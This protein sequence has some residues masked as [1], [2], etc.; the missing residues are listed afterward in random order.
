MNKFLISIVCCFCAGSLMT[1]CSVIADTDFDNWKQEFYQYAL[2]KG[3]SKPTLDQYVPQM[4]LLERVVHIDTKKPEYVANFYDY[5][6]S[7]IE[8][9]RINGGRKMAKKYKTWLR[10]V[11]EK[12]GVQ[13][14]YL[15]SFWGMETNY[16]NYMGRVKMLDSLASLSYHPRRRQFFSNELVAYLKI[17]EEEPS[18]APEIGSWD[19]GMGNF[20]FMPTTFRA[21]AVD[22]DNNH[23]R[24]IV[25]NIPDAL[26][27][28]AN[29]LS[30]MG[31]DSTEPWGR[32]IILPKDIDGEDIHH[33]RT[34]TVR[35]WRALGIKPKH[36][37]D[38]PKNEYDIKAY[39]RMPMGKT[40]P[41]FLTYP[42][43]N[44]ILRWNRSELY[45]LSVGILAD[46]LSDRRP[47]LTQPADFVPMKRVWVQQIQE[48]LAEQGLYKGKT[49]GSVG[50]KTRHAIRQYQIQNKLFP[51]GYP[52]KELF[53]KIVGY[54]E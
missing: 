12:Y 26:S 38:F 5:T 46:I 9:L 42:N 32:E 20:Q 25:R 29:Y 24:D 4:K 18:V 39:L 41:V 31:W 30:A 44:I 13:P 27:S 19:G 33:N 43:Y 8:P 47:P 14:E 28:A 51:D 6:K 40:G 17:M 21:Y 10:R 45:A 36:T 2:E 54:T 23:R 49:D 1:P 50:P 16:G 22:G 3:V 35:E 37:A 34:R 53:D 48:K 52:T 11:S 7:R 15:L